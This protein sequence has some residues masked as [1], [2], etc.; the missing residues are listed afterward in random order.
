M[1]IKKFITDKIKDIKKIDKP[2][3][4]GIDGPTAAGKTFLSKDLKA[5]L[6]KSFKNIW[7]CQL[8]WTLKSRA[9]RANS[10]KLFKDQ[11]TNF[12]YESQDHMDLDQIKKCLNKINEFDYKKNKSIKVNLKGLY[13][14]TTATNDLSISEKINKDSLIIVEGHYTSIIELDNVI[15]FNILLLAEKKE[16]LE[17]KINRVKHYRNS[18]D[19]KQ[20]FNLIDVPSFINHLSLF[21]CNYDLILDN[22]NYKKP[23]IKDKNY[24]HHWMDKLTTKNSSIDTFEDFIRKNFYSNLAS[25]LNF[26]SSFNIILNEFINF[27][28]FVS[29]NIK[30]NIQEINIDL[31]SYL[32]KILLLIN[33][34]IKSDNY[35]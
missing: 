19:T 30:I 5:L 31:S 7:I 32:H 26:K 9:Y 20:Y 2:T 4:I 11:N 28:K 25:Q 1:N 34:K 35:F 14:R 12:Y 16:L 23:K 24:I 21:G 6:K 10:L 18:E 27:D 8:D 22:T 17:R 33:K 3:I 29:N 13:N 15:D